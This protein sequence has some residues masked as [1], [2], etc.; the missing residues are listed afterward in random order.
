VWWCYINKN[1][2][3]QFTSCFDEQMKANMLKVN[4]TI[5]KK[6]NICKNPSAFDYGTNGVCGSGTWGSS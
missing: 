1:N 3:A 2:A 5:T 6:P 4:T